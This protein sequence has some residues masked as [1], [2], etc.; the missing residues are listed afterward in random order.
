MSSTSS[1]SLRSSS[2]ATSSCS[3]R[4][5][6]RGL[7]RALLFA[8][9]G[10]V[11]LVA[12]ACSAVLDFTECKSDADCGEFFTEDQKPMRCTESQCVPRAKCTSNSQCTGLGEGFICSLTGAC[13]A[14]TNDQCGAPIYPGGQ[15]SDEV[16][17]IGS[18]VDKT[19]PDAALGVASEAAFIQ[20]LE[21]FHVGGGILRSGKQ[22]ALI[23]CD[24]G[25][26]VTEAEAAAKHLGF[27][28]NVPAILGPLADD[29]LA[30]V[31]QKVSIVSGALAYTNSP[32]ATS[33]LSFDDLSLVWLT[34]IHS[35][36]QGRSFGEHL[37]YEIE[38]KTFGTGEPKATLLFAQDDYG[39]S[40]YHALATDK[41]EGQL[42]RIPEISSQVISSYRDVAAAK[43]SLDSFGDTDI[44]IL[45]GGTEVAELLAYY[46]AS[47]KPWPAR[48][49]VAQR[50]FAAVQA[51]GDK[52]LVPVLRAIGPNIESKNL[53][54]VRTRIGDPKAPAEVGLAYDAAMVTLLGMTVHSG[55]EPI[56]GVAIRSAMDKLNDPMGTAV[57]FGASP[58]TFI[59]AAAAAITAGKTINV[60]GASGPLDYSDQGIICGDMIAYALSADAKSFT[61]AERFAADCPAI[62][63]TWTP[64]G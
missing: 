33:E 44:L 63:G 60:D 20:A 11:G 8:L 57:S 48:V 19:G 49:Y 40:M 54:A 34:N 15:P 5:A 38:A 23:P 25:G 27:T 31:A 50:S 52:T 14:T 41:P 37:S 42:N 51:L 7:S 62:T 16:V 47:G 55:T 29:E 53:P 46:K 28:L 30:R 10:G 59:K 64:A 1:S 36:V 13:A 12:G 18:I 61:P 17:F 26:S 39:Y 2:S 45:F 9:A 3:P 21:D 24:S 58:A 4:G 6:S 32:L 43:K 56:T 22:V 35:V